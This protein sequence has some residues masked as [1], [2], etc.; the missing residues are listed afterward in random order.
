MF[1]REH[2]NVNPLAG[3][4]LWAN[5]YVTIMIWKQNMLG[6]QGC[7]GKQNQTKIK[8]VLGC[9]SYPAFLFP[10]AAVS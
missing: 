7:F 10:Q 9:F 1:W 3:S 8:R 6:L 4:N 2:F 5:Q